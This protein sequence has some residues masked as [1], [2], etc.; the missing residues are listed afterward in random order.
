MLAQKNLA[1]EGLRGIASLVVVVGHFTFVFFGYLG[2]LWR[3]V[4]GAQPTYP[5]ERIVEIPP[6][7]LIYSADAAVSVFFVMSGYVL[8]AKFYASGAAEEL[9][10]AAAKRFIRLVL[11]SFASV[12]FAWALW[13]SG[14]IL[15]SQGT[16]IG[17]AGWVPAWYQEQYTF[18]QA[19][20]NGLFGATFFGRAG[21]NPPLWSIQVELIGS[22]LL[23]SMLALYGKGRPVLLFGCFLFFANLLAYSTPNV[24]YYLS[25]LAGALLNPAANRLRQKQG[26]SVALFAAGLVLVAYCES[27]VYEPLRAMGLPNLQPFGPDFN[28]TPRI[29]WHSLGSVQLVAGTIGARPIARVLSV[30]PM[31]F[32][33]RISFS[34]YLIHMPL[35]MSLALW[36]CRQAQKSG[37]AYIE[38][39]GAAFVVYLAVV[40]WLSSLFARWV[41]APSIRL[42]SRV[43]E[44]VRPRVR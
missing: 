42:A 5:L 11:P 1:L 15:T 44:I 22:I 38:A 39:V 37:F 41:D 31:L 9:Q 8:T 32:L 12:M 7:V 13:H 36:V 16:Q 26:V 30:R 33:G 27:P 29:F 20:L 19:I 6:L 18:S 25:F 10:N 23:F 17:V 14:A 40:L 4:A 34:M 2:T 43:A 3:P 24:L 28:T 35:L 21:L